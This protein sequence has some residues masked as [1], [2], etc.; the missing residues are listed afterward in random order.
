MEQTSNIIN[1][2]DLENFFLNSN[3]DINFTNFLIGIL[4]S[5]FLDTVFNILK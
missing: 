5:L 3:I 4:L 2:K 1:R